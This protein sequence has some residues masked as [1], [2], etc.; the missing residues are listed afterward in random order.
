M[1][2]NLCLITLSV[3]AVIFSL[4]QTVAQNNGGFYDS[5]LISDEV[6]NEENAEQ[7]KQSAGKLLKTK[8]IEIK[9]DAPALRSHQKKVKKAKRIKKQTTPQKVLQ[10][11]EDAPFGLTWGASYEEVK[12]T[13]VNLTPVM[14]KDYLK[15]Y[16]ATNLQKKVSTFRE[17]ILTFGIED[18]LWRILAYGN[19]IEDTPSAEKVMDVYNQYYSLL[20]K[21]YGNAHQFFTPK[22]V[23]VDVPAGPGKQPT[24]V[25]QENP[26]GNPDFLQELQ[27]GEASLYAT[28]DNDKVGAALSVNVDGNGQSYIIIEYKN[29][30]ILKAREKTTF[31]AL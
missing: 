16:S 8:P 11:H 21:K 28:F 6:R 30:T 23:N 18:E 17:V 27:S 26:I 20:E 15:N 29:L 25:Q 10:K 7:A 19:F 12:Q 3:F 4:R 2:K 31:D 1:K 24:T 5:L 22:V 14:L 9:I 13:G